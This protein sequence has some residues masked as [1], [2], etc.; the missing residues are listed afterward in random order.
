MGNIIVAELA[1][2]E[3]LN[4]DRGDLVS[5]LILFSAAVKTKRHARWLDR[6]G[7]AKRI[8]V[9][10]N[11]H[12]AVLRFAGVAFK[13]DM[14]G[15]DLRPPGASSGRVTYVDVSGCEVNHR[16]FVPQGQTGHARLTTFYRQGVLGKAVDFSGLAEARTI[17]GVAV[18]RIVG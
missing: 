2:D 13:L 10:I 11:S 8:Y 16:Y 4:A 14:L 9:A 1:R 6:I 3:L 15:R 7:I 5:N 18:Q 17:D 12:D